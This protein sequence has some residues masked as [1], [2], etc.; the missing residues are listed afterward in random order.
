MILNCPRD[1]TELTQGKE[2]GIEVDR[3]PGCNGAWY[4]YEELEALESTVA[5]DHERTGMID[6]AKRQSELACPVCQKPMRAFNYRAHNL[7]LDACSEGHGFWLDE[8]ESTRVRDVMKDRVGG[9]RRAGSAE[10]AWERAKGSGAGGII[11]QI[12]G[13]FRR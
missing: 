7:E 2:G 9:L 10:K 8:G 3:C 1:A 12:K 13:L 11:G 6:Y 4:D 5:D